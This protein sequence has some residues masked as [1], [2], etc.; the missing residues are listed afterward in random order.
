MLK[1]QKGEIHISTV[2]V[3]SHQKLF[4][5]YLSVDMNDTQATRHRNLLAD[6]L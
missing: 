4:I 5:L 3:L 6:F 1:M 2:A